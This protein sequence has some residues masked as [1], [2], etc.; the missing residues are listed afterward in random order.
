MREYLLEVSVKA[1]SSPL[2]E[3]Q[4]RAGKKSNNNG[5]N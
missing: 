4:K 1:Y 5:L 3:T 2:Y